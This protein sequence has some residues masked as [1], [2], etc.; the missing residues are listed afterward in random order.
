MEPVATEPRGIEREFRLMSYVTRW[1]IVQTLRKQ[2]L[3]E[4]QYHVAVLALRLVREMGWEDLDGVDLGH[5]LEEAL[6]HD[7]DELI[8]SDIPSPVN[9]KIKSMGGSDWKEWLQAKTALFFPW[10]RERPTHNIKQIVR[11]CDI[12]EAMLFLLEEHGMGNGYVLPHY[13][14]LEGVMD[15]TLK[16]TGLPNLDRIQDWISRCLDN[17]VRPARPLTLL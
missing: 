5:L 3:A 1:Q 15:V 6:L 11:I 10:Y 2:N 17:A 4:H 12:L 14:V 7:I 13:R 9:Q 8:S 16:S